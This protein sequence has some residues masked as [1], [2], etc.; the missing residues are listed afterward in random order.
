MRV[1]S[2]DPGAVHTGVA[3]WSDLHGLW[4]CQAAVEMSYG[5]YLDEILGALCHDPVAKPD[6]LVIEGFWLKP[7]KAA[8]QQAGSA[9]ETVELIGATLAIG[10]FQDIEVIKVANGQDSQITR[11]TAAGYEWV[12][13]GHGGHAKDAEAVGPR[14]LGL[15]VHEIEACARA[16]AKRGK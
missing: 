1:V 2:V 16:L 4:A 8:L 5:Q 3:Y 9:L 7:G 6:K 12:S 15:K 10:R 14:G 13:K 11:M